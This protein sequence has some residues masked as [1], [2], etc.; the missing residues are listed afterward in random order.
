MS[1]PYHEQLSN[2]TKLLRSE[3]T[4][5][6]AEVEL[7]SNI[8]F[9]E[10]RFTDKE[11]A[12]DFIEREKGGWPELSLTGFDLEANTVTFLVRDTV[13]PPYAMS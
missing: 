6:A 10:I 3:D 7:R 12:N 13:E 1:N 5:L 8:A 11:A 2:L 4:V 9:C